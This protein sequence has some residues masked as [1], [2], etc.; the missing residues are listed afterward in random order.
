MLG[1][2]CVC[3]S[4]VECR[5]D[6]HGIVCCSHDAWGSPCQGAE[7]FPQVVL[8]SKARNW[9]VPKSE[10]RFKLEPEKPMQVS[11]DDGETWMWTF[12]SI[13]ELQQMHPSMKELNPEVNQ[14]TLDE[15]EEMLE[16]E[17]FGETLDEEFPDDLWDMIR[18]I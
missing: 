18:M 9:I 16:R 6:H 8:K 12:R 7:Q 2:C 15:D 10:I 14:E 5:Q 11:T 13:E 17:L 4:E 1:I 3:Q